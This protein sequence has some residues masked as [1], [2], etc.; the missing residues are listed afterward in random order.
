MRGERK[1]RSRSRLGHSV[2][3]AAAIASLIT[4]SCSSTGAA[5]T[6]EPSGSVG[7]SPGDDVV[8]IGD[9]D[10]LPCQGTLEPGTYRAAFHDQYGEATFPAV[11][12]TVRDPGWTWYYSGNFRIVTDDAPSD[13]LTRYSEGIYVL[14]APRAASSTCEEVPEPGVG[15]TAD[16]LADWLEQR[17]GLDV[18]GRKP[19]T[20]GGLRGVQLDIAMDPAWTKTCPFSEGLPAVPLIVRNSEFAGYHFALVPG[21]SQRWF[22]LPWDG[23]VILIDIDNSRG[24]MT[25]DALIEAATPI[26]ESFG[27]SAA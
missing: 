5:P 20:I 4:A 16:K 17:A 2:F 12:F 14:L 8:T 7:P 24:R 6:A 23:G 22:L 9:C 13:G 21:L 19:V 15:R 1:R 18:T 10:V 26:V 27:F 3:V 11:G 25:A